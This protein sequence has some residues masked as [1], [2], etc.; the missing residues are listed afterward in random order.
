MGVEVLNCIE[1]QAGEEAEAHE[2]DTGQRAA[3]L[4][5]Q[6]KHVQTPKPSTGLLT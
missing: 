4:R 5:T 1:R 6:R 3:S 2:T